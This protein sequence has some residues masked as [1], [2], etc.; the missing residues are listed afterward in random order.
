MIESV[1]FN[2]KVSNRILGNFR[3]SVVSVCMKN[4]E[5]IEQFVLKL[6]AS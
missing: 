6:S 4:D 2:L 1:A 5:A 3:E